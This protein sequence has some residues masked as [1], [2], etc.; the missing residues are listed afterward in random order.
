M[1][2]PGHLVAAILWLGMGLVLFFGWRDFYDGAR[3]SHA[4]VGRLLGVPFKPKRFYRLLT[5][6]LVIAVSLGC[7]FGAVTE[8]EQALT[9]RESRLR[10]A[11]TW[12]AIWP[13]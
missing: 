11:Q 13:F 8:A 1:A 10:M 2:S 4:R 6:V 5:R 3:R 12:R 9:G 7:L